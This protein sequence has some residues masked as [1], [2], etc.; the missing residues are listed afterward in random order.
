MY[1]ALIV[2]FGV[3]VPLTGGQREVLEGRGAVHAGAVDGHVLAPHDE[4]VLGVQDGAGDAARLFARAQPTLPLVALALPDGLLLARA[5]VAW[6][7][8]AVGALAEEASGLAALAAAGLRARPPLGR[9]PRE[10]RA[11]APLVAA[12]RCGRRQRRVALALGR[13]GLRVHPAVRVEPPAAHGAELQA[14]AT[15]LRALRGPESGV[16]ARG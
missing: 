6:G 3:V 5:A 15:A 7:A 10:G 8:A 2:D 4:L 11:A 12:L 16:S 14:A 13:H 1:K 9:L